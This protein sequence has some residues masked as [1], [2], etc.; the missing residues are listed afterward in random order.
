MVTKLKSRNITEND[1][2]ADA[3]DLTKVSFI[4]HYA[5]LAP[6]SWNAQPWMFKLYGN[7]IKI[8]HDTERLQSHRDPLGRENIIS[9]GAALCNLR[10]ALNRFGFIEDTVIMPPNSEENLVAEITWKNSGEAGKENRLFKAIQQRHCYRKPFSDKIVDPELIEFFVSAAQ[11]YDC[12][13]VPITTSSTQMAL[14]GMISEGDKDLGSDLATR[15]EYAS[16]VRSS[17]RSEDGVPGYAMG[18]MS[19]VASILAPLTHRVFNYT[20]E[21]ARGD[22]ALT[23]ATTLLGVITS[24]T[25]TPSDWVQ[26]GQALERILLSAAA[27]GL[28]ASFLNQ[29]IAVE[30]LRK[31]LQSLLGLTEWPQLLLRIGYP[32][33]PPKITARRKLE[34]V[35]L[36][37]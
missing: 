1:F 36:I 4:L 24:H 3:D 35:L 21:F 16:W 31:R 28:Q 20:D 22:Q 18:N 10:I 33:E 13:F 7:T 19:T 26:S 17:G 29:P 34:D 30:E 23:C 9:C 2:P 32:T 12:E 11:R 6:S 15:K 37:G 14:A 5:I 25:D 8:F 27:N